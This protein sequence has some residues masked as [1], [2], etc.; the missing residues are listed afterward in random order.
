M[1]ADERIFAGDRLLV[2]PWPDGLVDATGHEASSPYVETFWLPILGPTATLLWRRLARHLDASPEGVELDL[3]STARALGVRDGAG[4]PTRLRRALARLM[5]FELA[6]PSGEALAVRRRL[7]TLSAHLAAQL[8]DP[9]GQVH[10]RLLAGGG[11]PGGRLG[12]AAAAPASA[13]GSARLVAAAPPGAS[14]P[15][16]PVPGRPPAPSARAGSGGSNP[17]RSSTIVRTPKPVAPFVT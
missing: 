17:D 13:P 16:H 6:R 14:R 8:P 12:S 2:V 1:R 9:L 11:V 5:R 10:R 7:P 3:P 15:A 4:R